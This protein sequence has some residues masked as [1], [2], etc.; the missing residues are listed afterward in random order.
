MQRFYLV[1][2]TLDVVF[3]TSEILDRPGTFLDFSKPETLDDQLAEIY[4]LTEE[5]RELM[6]KNLKP[7]K[8]KVDVEADK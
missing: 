5:E 2:L 4:E 3:A 8:D 6:R 1:D 7:W